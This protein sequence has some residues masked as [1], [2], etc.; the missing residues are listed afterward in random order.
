MHIH[1]CHQHHIIHVCDVQFYKSVYFVRAACIECAQ[2]DRK[3]GEWGGGTSPGND[4][5][6]KQLF[7]A[8]SREL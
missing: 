8:L 4:A 5:Y 2:G 7:C 3:K 6:Q 1:A